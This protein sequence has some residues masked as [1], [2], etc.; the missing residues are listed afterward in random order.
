[1]LTEIINIVSGFVTCTMSSI[2]GG[3]RQRSRILS[4]GVPYTVIYWITEQPIVKLTF[5]SLSSDW[6][7]LIKSSNPSKSRSFYWKTVIRKKTSLTSVWGRSMIIT[8]HMSS[9]RVIRGTS[10]SILQKF[11]VY[12]VHYFKKKSKP[13]ASCVANQVK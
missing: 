13:C 5:D 11:L 8:M 6:F 7:P 3:S 1:M 2:R 4:N 12:L 10:H 9:S